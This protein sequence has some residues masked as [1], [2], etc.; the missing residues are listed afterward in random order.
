MRR[1]L[2]L[3]AFV[4]FVAVQLIDLVA[5]WRSLALNKASRFTNLLFDEGL[6]YTENQLFSRFLKSL[7]LLCLEDD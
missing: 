6:E 3:M 7:S 1:V 4:R 5:V 2:R